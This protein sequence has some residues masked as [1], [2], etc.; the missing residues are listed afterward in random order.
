MLSLTG[1]RGRM[2]R[3]ARVTLFARSLRSL[4]T[5]PFGVLRARF[6][7]LGPPPS[8]VARDPLTG[9]RAPPRGRGLSGGVA[10]SDGAKPRLPLCG[11]GWLASL[12]NGA[13][14]RLRLAVGS[15]AR[16][17]LQSPVSSW[18]LDRARL[19]GSAFSFRHPAPC[20]AICGRWL[21]GAWGVSPPHG[22]APRPLGSPPARPHY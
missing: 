22:G 12:A 9:T 7:R 14:A 3:G 1:T 19:S 21:R 17:V 4:A 11:P 6:A 20:L 2:R 5:C 13:A 15:L 8:P 10:Q 16:L 18:W